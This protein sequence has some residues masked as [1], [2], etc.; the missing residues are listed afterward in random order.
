MVQ[1]GPERLTDVSYDFREMV[2]E[3]VNGQESRD[4]EFFPG[5]G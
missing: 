2:G 4:S 3:K 1:A 5:G